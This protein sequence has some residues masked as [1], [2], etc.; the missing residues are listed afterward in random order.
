M[1]FS[2][3]NNARTILKENNKPHS[4]NQIHSHLALNLLKTHYLGIQQKPIHGLYLKPPTHLRTCSP[5]FTWP[6][7]QYATWQA[8]RFRHT[9]DLE[10]KQAGCIVSCAMDFETSVA[11]CAG[12]FIKKTQKNKKYLRLWS[13]NWFVNWRKFSHMTLLIEL[14]MSEPQDF[15]NYMRMSEKGF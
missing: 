12:V 15:K 5:N 10:I 6:R 9:V 11:V 3:K 8:G 1:V 13:K 14:A 2:W 4:Y 7:T